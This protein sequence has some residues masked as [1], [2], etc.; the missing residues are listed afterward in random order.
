MNL[1]DTENCEERDVVIQS[2]IN[3]FKRL[4]DT[5]N[6]GIIGPRWEEM[7]RNGIL[8]IVLSGRSDVSWLDVPRLFTDKAFRKKIL[9]DV[10]ERFI[11]EFW[12]RI[13]LSSSSRDY[14][15]TISWFSSKFSAFS[16][17]SVM[18][19]IFGDSN[20]S[21]S[22]SEVLEKGK[23]LL[24]SLNRAKIGDI[25]SRLLGMI[26]ANGLERAVLARPLGSKSFH[27]Y[28]D[29]FSQF[30]LE[31]FVALF[32]EARKFGLTITVANQHLDQL[33][34]RLLASV[35]GNVGTIISF[36]VGPMDAPRLSIFYQP[37]FVSEELIN[38]PNFEAAVRVTGTEG[39]DAFSLVSSPEVEMNNPDVIETR[40]CQ[41]RDE[42]I[43]NMEKRRKDENDDDHDAA[44]TYGN[45]PSEP[46]RKN[47]GGQDT[48]RDSCEVDEE[49]EDDSVPSESI[50]EFFEEE[51]N[52]IGKFFNDE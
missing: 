41:A 11:K 28:I 45:T 10:D 24:V 44:L 22:F 12:E 1:F 51:T 46:A 42:V 37:R 32:A 23:I 29:E 16:S 2:M 18:R 48:D 25:N 4:Y 27:C 38:L 5:H 35:L 8:T 19:R 7:F 52:N 47:N 26:L 17:D 6:E 21:F 33:D 50:I 34:G 36:R 9:K 20:S 3:I 43:R 30:A 40:S 49:A 15:D 13:D 31:S 14:G 39:W